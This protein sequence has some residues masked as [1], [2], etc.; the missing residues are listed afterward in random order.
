MNRAEPHGAS[1]LAHITSPVQLYS[2]SPIKV[3]RLYEGTPLRSEFIA[4]NCRF[5]CFLGI[6]N[7][8]SGVYSIVAVMCGH[9]FSGL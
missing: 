8:C 4:T 3:F 2:Y 7:C 6:G 9:S 1:L 5:G